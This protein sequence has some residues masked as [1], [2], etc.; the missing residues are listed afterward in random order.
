MRC[1]NNQ[2]T[3][4]GEPLFN[5]NHTQCNSGGSCCVL[6]ANLGQCSC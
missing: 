6:G 4:C 5:Q 2:C 3:S 1:S